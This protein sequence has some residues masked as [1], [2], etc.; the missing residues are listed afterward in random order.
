M[1]QP[2]MVFEL[3][4]K[5]NLWLLLS[6]LDQ[7]WDNN[8]QLDMELDLL[9]QELNKENQRHMEGIMISLALCCSN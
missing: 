3:F 6:Y 5:R 1:C 9:F 7:T 2:D 8:I 4:L